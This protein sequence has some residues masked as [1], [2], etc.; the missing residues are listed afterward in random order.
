MTGLF[1]AT[2]GIADGQLTRPRLSR[3]QAAGRFFRNPLGEMAFTWF[4]IRERDGSA[5]ARAERTL[6]LEKLDVGQQVPKPPAPAPGVPPGNLPPLPPDIPVP[7][8]PPPPVENPGDVPLPPITD[9]EVIEPGEPNPARPPMH[10]L[11]VRRGPE[12]QARPRL[13]PARTAGMSWATYSQVRS[14]NVR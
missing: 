1:N 13:K 5:A 14:Y 6:A 11:G 12:Y 9:P 3:F 8:P 2:R 4:I 10:V 7:D